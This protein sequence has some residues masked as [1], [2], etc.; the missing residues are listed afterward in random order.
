MFY[1]IKISN[2][3]DKTIS[4]L[5]NLSKKQIINYIDNVLSKIPNPRL[6]GKQLK[7]SVLWRY[8][9]GN[10]RLICKINDKELIILVLELGHRKDIYS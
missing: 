8:R 5:D 10:F 2:K 1:E 9:T 4:K 6:L 3:A 7:G